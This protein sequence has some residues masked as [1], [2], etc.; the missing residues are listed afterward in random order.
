VSDDPQVLVVGLGNALRGDDGAG[1]AVAQRLG[2]TELPAGVRVQALE[3]EPLHL[4]ERW[5]AGDVVLIIDTVRSGA[6]PGTIHRFDVSSAR[7]PTSLRRT[8]SHAIGL[9]ET[10]ELARVLHRLPA[11]VIVF[12]IEGA[13]FRAGA[14][15]DDPI[16]RAVEAVSERVGEEVLSYRTAARSP[17]PSSAPSGEPATQTLRGGALPPRKES[18]NSGLSMSCAG[19]PSIRTRPPDST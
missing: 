13:S 10:I 17:C 11:T 2:Q 5:S 7:L 4:L 19:V 18:T 6:A 14:D 9:A 12:G 1:L 15:L 3:G 16:Q 8:S